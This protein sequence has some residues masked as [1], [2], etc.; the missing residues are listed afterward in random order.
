MA[1]ID[2][3]PKPVALASPEDCS[4]WTADARAVLQLGAR[5]W[6]AAL[7][8]VVL[9][10][11][12]FHQR[13]GADATVYA[14]AHAWTDAKNQPTTLVSLYFA[15]EAAVSRDQ[16]DAI[17]TPLRASTTGWTH[18]G[19]H[20]APD[21]AFPILA[22]VG[23]AVHH[24]WTEHP[25]HGTVCTV[26]AARGPRARPEVWRH[27]NSD[28]DKFVA[29]VAHAR[30]A[31]NEAPDADRQLRDQLKLAFAHRVAEQVIEAD[32]TVD[33]DERAFLERTFPPEQ[34]E[35]LWL[36]DP[37]E[38]AELADR[39]ERELRDRLGYHEKLGLLSTFY[40]ACYADGKVAVQELMV[41]K[42][43]S[44]ALGLDRAEV[45][46]YLQRMW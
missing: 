23:G 8:E 22:V 32:G 30:G 12:S 29:G 28:P 11:Q 15:T 34:L 46:Q 18:D 5:P 27:A 39:A 6:R 38:R 4:T 17:G 43:A 37:A 20:A 44:N 10:L 41:L 26:L 35:A 25:E 21:Y 3:K 1:V 36:D 2:L 45:V 7:Q 14:A 33:D 40:A 31:W 13:S 9:A 24:L 42:N 16:L 19:V